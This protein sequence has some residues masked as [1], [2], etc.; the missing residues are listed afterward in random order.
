MNR[1][2]IRYIDRLNYQPLSPLNFNPHSFP[3]LAYGGY[4]GICAWNQVIFY[5]WITDQGRPIPNSPFPIKK[6]I[7]APHLT[8]AEC[9]FQLCPEQNH[10]SFWSN[11][12]ISLQLLGLLKSDD[13]IFGKL[14]KI[15]IYITW[16]E[17]G[18]LK[19][20]K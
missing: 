2:A 7:R 1:H 4:F 13:G 8:S 6:K 3:Q 11:N 10:P 15:A 12:P 19:S 20:F 5:T 16:I 14:T 18:F 17:F 9:R